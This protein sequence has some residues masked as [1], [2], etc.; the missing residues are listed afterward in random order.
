M[1]ICLSYQFAHARCTNLLK[2]NC[3]LLRETRG[4]P[5]L[6]CILDSGI[7]MLVKY[8]QILFCAQLVASL[9][10]NLFYWVTYK[11]GLMTLTLV[12]NP[13]TGLRNTKPQ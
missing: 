8:K 11:K 13:A 4:L 10:E 3:K 2:I 12:G 5:I 6:L 7:R 1:N 9:K